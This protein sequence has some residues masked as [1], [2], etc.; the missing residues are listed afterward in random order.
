MSIGLGTRVGPYEILASIGAG[1]MGEVYRARDTRLNRDVAVKVLPSSFAADEGRLRRF[2]LEAQSAGSLNHP[3]ILAIHDIGE[4]ER[5]PYIVSELLEGESLRQ[6]LLGGKLSVQKALDYA[7]QVAAGLAAAHGKGITHRDIKPENLFVTR[8]GRMKILDFGLAKMRTMDGGARG[9]SDGDATQTQTQTTPGAVLGTVAYM[10]PEQVRGEPADHRSDIFSFGCVLYEMLTGKRAFRGDTSV[11]TMSAILKEEP[12]ELSTVEGPLPPALERIVRHCLEK[13]PEERF[14]SARD[15]AFDLGSVSQTSATGSA[16]QAS[17]GRSRRWIEWA[18]VLVAVGLAVAAFFVGRK[19]A[20]EQEKQFHRLTFRRGTIHAARFAPDGNTIV[21]SASWEDEPSDIFSAR[22]E[23]PES[24]SLAFRGST[25]LG[26]SSTGELALA[27]NPRVAVSAFAPA[28]TLAQAPFSGGAP[29]SIEEKIAFADWSPDGK[30]LAIV[31]ETDK[32][33][34]LEYPAG[35]VLYRTAGYLSHARVSPASDRI[36]FW[37]HPLSNDNAGSVAIVNRSGEKKELTGKYV[38]ADGLAW[39]SDGNEVWFTGAAKGAR[40]DLYAVS[41]SGKLRLVH[42]QSGS[43][44][45]QD[46]AR[47]GRVLMA[48]LEWRQKMMFRGAADMIEREI[49]WLDWSL[50]TD[51]SPDGRMITFSESGEGARGDQIVYVR[52]PGGDAAVKLGLGGGGYFTRDG[53]SLVSVHPSSDLIL[54]YPVGT[55]QAQRVALKGFTIGDAGPMPDGE[56]IWFNGNEPSHGPRIYITNLKGEKPRAVSPEGS[57]ATRP[58][59]T[60]DGKYVTGRFQGKTWLFPVDGG[61]PQVV[62]GMLENERITAWSPDNQWFLVYR[63]S[64]LPAKVYKVDR[65]TGRREFVREIGPADRAG[66]G[67]SGMNLLMTPD[68][69][70]YVY[71]TQQSLSELHVVEGLR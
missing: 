25:L 11:E 10:S 8:D 60:S 14:Q 45:L 50:P 19:S 43:I 18:P 27:L 37:D 17:K 41:L 40:L 9:S 36:A 46:I 7:Q 59:A 70:N 22:L 23:S 31:R 6:R 28:G 51:I 2:T 63:R 15:L 48:N 61:E 21:Y 55:G 54:V 4:H 68:G 69:K 66:V 65:A 16:R 42:R 32:G 3:N 38:A 24:R 5:T 67:R 53:R 57:R 49:S 34:Q 20:P 62:G 56:R 47:D 71:S 30:E 33:M 12:A 1:G 26:L 52:E 35:K 64:D 39:S 13:S 29:R 58:G 44:S